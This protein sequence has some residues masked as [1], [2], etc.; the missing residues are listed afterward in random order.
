VTLPRRITGF[1]QKSEDN[2]AITESELEKST[3]LIT[4]L[5]KE[6]GE[7]RHKADEHDKLKDQLDE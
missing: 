3:N 1:R 7:L 2:L 5:T 4:D 6:I